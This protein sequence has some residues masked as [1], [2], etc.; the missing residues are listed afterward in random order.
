M[1]LDGDENK[2]PMESSVGQIFVGDNLDLDLVQSCQ[3]G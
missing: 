2:F 3:M 1:V